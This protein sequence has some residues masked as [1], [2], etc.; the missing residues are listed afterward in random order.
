MGNQSVFENTLDWMPTHVLRLSDADFCLLFHLGMISPEEKQ[1][2][3][4]LAP[5]RAEHH[6]PLLDVSTGHIRHVLRSN[7]CSLSTH[8][9]NL[10][11]QPSVGAGPAG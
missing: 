7:K 11:P 9:S 5:S 6:P 3:C 1:G 10:Q 2:S 8:Y 4:E